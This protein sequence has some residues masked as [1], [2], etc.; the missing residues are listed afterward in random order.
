[1]TV[2]H[3]APRLFALLALPFL[4][5]CGAKTEPV[6]APIVGPVAG[7]EGFMDNGFYIEPVAADLLTPAQRRTEV[8]FPG[9]EPVGS[10]VV[11]TFA[12]K[13]YHVKEGHR[14]MRY[15]IAVGREGISFQGTGTI[16]RKAEWPSWQPTANMLATRPDLYAKYAGGRPGGADNPLGSR[17]MYLYKNG[18][19]TYFRIHGTIQNESI[20]RA[21]SA[22]CIRMFNQDVIQ[23]FEEIKLGTQVKV[24]TLP[25]SLA[26]EGP[27]MDDARGF[28]V[29]N[30][31][32][33]EAQK[34][35]ELDKMAADEAAKLAAAA[36][37]AEEQAKLRAKADKKRLREC[38]RNKIEPADCP[39]LPEEASQEPEKEEPYL[40]LPAI[41]EKPPEDVATQSDSVIAAAD[42]AI[43][44]AEMTDAEKAADKKRLADCLLKDI[45]AELCPPL[46]TPVQP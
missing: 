15:A 37:L 41:S 21:T 45:P 16:Q 44:Q 20:G 30:T 3:A 38:K 35:A 9:D 46:P 28:A 32:E 12:R 13:L 36:K 34:Q 39:P 27:F 6:A 42:K 4:V 43:A 10:I 5:A 17:A 25:E 29:P 31:A 1:L 2:I 23:L 18:R 22:G 19:D 11:D 33:M 7:Y 24:R 8:D 40:G 26:A 14:A